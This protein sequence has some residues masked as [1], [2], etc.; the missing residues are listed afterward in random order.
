M[1]WLDTATSCALLGIKP[2]SLYAYV[3][4]GLVRAHTAGDDPRASVYA[5][6]DI[7]K[8]L[9]RK[10]A[11][12][13]RDSIARGAI[14]WGE[15]ILESAIATVHD[16]RLIFRGHDAIALSDDQTLEQVASLLWGDGGL[17]LSPQ[18][19]ELIELSDP[20]AAGFDYLARM[21]ATALPCVGRPRDQLA[22][23]ASTLLEGLSHAMALGNPGLGAHHKLAALWQLS[24]EQTNI[25]RRALVLLADHE[26]NPSTF[27]ARIAA[28]TGASLAASALAGFTTLTGPYHGEAASRALAFLRD[29]QTFGVAHAVATF[30]EEESALPGLGHK[31]YPDGDPR[32]R[33]LLTALK[34]APLLSD[35]IDQ[36]EKASSHLANIDMALAALTVHWNLPNTA[37]FILFAVARTAG[38][39]AHGVEQGLS[40]ALM[41]PRAR[42]VGPKHT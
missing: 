19:A 14:G 10:R 9:T 11:G 22:Q 36:A 1:K 15:P 32:A 38:W 24:D 8:L 26:L 42:Y 18:S 12:R 2:A 41:R 27:A 33:A 31:L 35:A 16:G 39:L 28:S 3:S 7:D 20:K 23:E 40:G 4:R 25:L 17:P 29:A 6:S 30:Q 21:A 13:K 34:P 37:P 5:A